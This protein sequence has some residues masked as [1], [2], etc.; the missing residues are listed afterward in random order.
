MAKDLDKIEDKAEDSATKVEAEATVIK[1]NS[2]LENLKTVFTTDGHWNKK[3]IEQLSS[4]FWKEWIEVRLQGIDPLIRYS[5][6][7]YPDC[8]NALF[9]RFAKEAPEQDIDLTLFQKGAAE[10][11]VKLNPNEEGSEV[12]YVLANIL[13]LIA[14]LKAPEAKVMNTLRDW[15]TKENLLKRS[16]WPLELHRSALY[17]LAALQERGNSED[18]AI[19][20]KWFNP[21]KDAEQKERLIFLPAAFSGLALS[22]KTVPCAELLKLLNYYKQSINTDAR[23]RISPAILALWIGRELENESVKQELWEAINQSTTSEENWEII[24]RCA[25]RLHPEILPWEQMHENIH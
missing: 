13:E 14:I 5:R 21:W 19:W 15:I 6:D 17:A 23:L 1:Q 4:G 7:E 12:K 8:A 2:F 10:L 16:D 25:D 20:Q 3:T 24:R 11:F 18:E 9:L 22:R